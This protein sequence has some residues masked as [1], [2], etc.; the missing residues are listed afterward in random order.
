MLAP[1]SLVAEEQP[2]QLGELTAY[3]SLFPRQ[4]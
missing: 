2:V 3:P 1:V 4:Q